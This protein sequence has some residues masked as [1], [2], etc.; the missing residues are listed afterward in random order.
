[1]TVI[2][3]VKDKRALESDSAAQTAGSVTECS[4]EHDG[5][6]GVSSYYLNYE[7]HVPASSLKTQDQMRSFGMKVIEAG[8]RYKTPFCPG[9][10][11]V[12]QWRHCQSVDRC[13]PAVRFQIVDQLHIPVNPVERWRCKHPAA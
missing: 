10:T 9:V 11:S 4:T 7:L 3:S 8:A 2:T 5:Y 13:T 1:M 6:G 12:A